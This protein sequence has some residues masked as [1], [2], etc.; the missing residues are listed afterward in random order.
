MSLP[1]SQLST[2]SICVEGVIMN[3]KLITA[4]KTL[5]CLVCTYVSWMGTPY[6]FFSNSFGI[7]QKKK[8]RL[9]NI[10]MIKSNH[11]KR[12]AENTDSS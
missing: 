9:I 7:L 11:L 5:F 8:G 3:L 4:V 10:S 1:G 6:P 12:V 2:L